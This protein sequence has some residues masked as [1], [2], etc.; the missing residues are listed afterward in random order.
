MSATGEPPLTREAADEI[1]AMT[2]EQICVQIGR[3]AAALHVKLGG[4]LAQSILRQVAE[5]IEALE[6]E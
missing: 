2:V 6:V 4:D 5:Q 1:D 3:L